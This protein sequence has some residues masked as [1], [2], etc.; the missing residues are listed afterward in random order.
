[1]NLKTFLNMYNGCD[2]KILLYNENWKHIC[3]FYNNSLG[4]KPYRFYDVVNFSVL[5]MKGSMPVISV[6]IN[7]YGEEME[8]ENE[9]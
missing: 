9:R 6:Y 5:G 4:I 1:M 2:L 7:T 8:E 3:D